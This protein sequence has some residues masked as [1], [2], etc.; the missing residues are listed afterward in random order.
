[1][2]L[3]SSESRTTASS[4]S[5]EAASPVRMPGV[6]RRAHDAVAG[7]LGHLLGVPDGLV[8]AGL[9]QQLDRDEPEQRDGDQAAQRELGDGTGD[10]SGWHGL[11]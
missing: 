6:E 8:A 2:S 9:L 5:I 11:H 7:Q 3:R 1:M 10:G 4:F